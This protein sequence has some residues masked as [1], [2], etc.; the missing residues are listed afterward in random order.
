MPATP[1]LDAITIASPCMESWHGMTGD[2]RARYCKRCRLHVY[3]LSAMTR[4]EAETLLQ[5]KEGQACVRF[6]ERADGTVLTRECPGSVA[7]LQ[8]LFV[9][10]A[11]GL[12]SFAVLLFAMI[13]SSTPQPLSEDPVVRG[14]DDKW[15]GSMID[16]FFPPG[17]PPA[18]P[19]PCVMGKMATSE[20]SRFDPPQRPVGAPP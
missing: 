4:S 17:A 18:P 12:A 2:E 16:Y 5:K 20:M 19:T 3:N 13:L 10:T 15:L 11:A 14:R 7:S 8:R 1:F 6:Y 9:M